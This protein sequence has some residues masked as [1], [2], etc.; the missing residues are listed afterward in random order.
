MS[1]ITGFGRVAVTAAVLGPTYFGNL[2]QF[3]SALPMLIYGL[4]SGSLISAML[5]PPLVRCL[6]TK[7]K[8]GA[9]Q[10]ANGFLGTLLA[11]FLCVAVLSILGASLLLQVMTAAVQDA[12]VRREQLR[13]GWPLLALMLPQLLLCGT[14]G[15]CAAVQQANER[16]SLAAAAPAAENLAAISVLAVFA[17]LH[18][19]GVEIQNVSDDHVLLLGLGMTA[20]VALCTAL[21]WWGASRVGFRLLPS[22]GWRQ[23]DIRRMFRTGASS[24]GY[25][26]LSVTTFFGMLT[27][28]GG[29]PGGVAAF[30]IAAS[31]SYMPVALTAGA[32]SAV[33]L[34]QLSRCFHEGSLHA[35]AETYRSSVRL[36][37]F[38]LLPVVLLMVAI[39][40]TLAGAMAFGE[41]AAQAGVTLIAA[42]I[43]GRALGILGEAILVVGTSASYA[44][45][46]VGSPLRAMAL[47][48]GISL[49]GM[50]VAH[51]TS[52]PVTLMWVL[53]ATVT[54]AASAA[55]LYLHWCQ[56]RKLPAGTARDLQTIGVNLLAAV[57]ASG[58]A[59]LIVHHAA[60]APDTAWERLLLAVVATLA[61][62]VTYLLLQIIHGSEEM[63]LLLPLPARLRHGLEPSRAERPLPPSRMSADT[64][65]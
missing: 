45:R 48:M 11:I 62:A 23:P 9:R 16:F 50:I 53:G 6:D 39:P 61:T 27:I 54:V 25:T 57:V 15:V 47:L 64:T 24:L 43:A 35:F 46:D 21:Q 29:V 63:A 5:V 41:M 59:W 60:G 26:G 20:A 52:N 55:A 38:A 8:A 32:L 34:P 13:L 37:L 12:E 22:A 3:S 33:Q 10:L 65:S 42:C 51:G 49:A 28:A 30:Q 14:S 17:L 18:G 44:R 4:L 58:S 2:F 19:T 40:E 31:L 56:L 1:R 36:V 7:D